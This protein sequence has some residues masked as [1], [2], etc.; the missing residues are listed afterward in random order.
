MATT[1]AN[2]TYNTMVITPSSLPLPIQTPEYGD[3]TAEITVKKTYRASASTKG[4]G[5]LIPQ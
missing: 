1:T 3:I 4:L 2:N 5:F